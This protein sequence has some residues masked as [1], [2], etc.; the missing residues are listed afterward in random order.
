MDNVVRVCSENLQGQEDLGDVLGGSFLGLALNDVSR[1]IRIETLIIERGDFNALSFGVT[2]FEFCSEDLLRCLSQS[3]VLKGYGA[4]CL[5]PQ[6]EATEFAYNI[7]RGKDGEITVNYERD[8]LSKTTF[9]GTFL[10]KISRAANGKD[11]SLAGS[12]FHGR[13]L[14]PDH[15]KCV[16][17]RVDREIRSPE[18]ILK[19]G[20]DAF[21]KAWERIKR[22]AS[23]DDLHRSREVPSGT[24]R[25]MV[26]NMSDSDIL[27]FV[28][29]EEMKG[30][31]LSK[32][33]LANELELNLTR[34]VDPILRGEEVR[35]LGPT[36]KSIANALNM[37]WSDIVE[38]GRRLALESVS[39][40]A[41]S[42]RADVG[43]DAATRSSDSPPRA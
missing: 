22:A 43:G 37:S 32:T 14:V 24:D 29:T 42:S 8:V 30:R 12:F 18:E 36:K 4:V 1:E 17:Y 31:H 2:V 27:R 38:R 34:Q 26:K 9:K 10:L 23:S 20:V 11:F 33:T 15:G 39:Q 25:R 19:M 28:F 40:H 7:F 21:V 16:F 6:R 3:S 13:Q 5:D 41:H 35:I